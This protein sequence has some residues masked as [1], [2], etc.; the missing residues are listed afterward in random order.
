MISDC[1]DANMPN[2]LYGAASLTANKPTASGYYIIEYKGWSEKYGYQ[3]AYS[4]N[5]STPKVY[6]RSQGVSWGAWCQLNLTAVSS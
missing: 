3:I 4:V 5:T 1:D 2:V 6:I